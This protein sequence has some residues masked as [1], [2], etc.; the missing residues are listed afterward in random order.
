LALPFKFRHGVE[1]L[2]STVLALGPADKLHEKELYD[3]L[4]AIAS[5]ELFHVWNVKTIRPVE[6]MPY[7]YAT[8]NYAR[9]G[10]V[11]EGVTTYYGDLFLIRCHYFSIPEYFKQ[12]DK[13]LMKH[14]H[15]AGRFNL[16]V[17]DSSFDTWLDGYVIGIPDR[18][19]SIYDEGSLIALILDLMIINQSNCKYSLDDVMRNLYN[20]FGKKKHGYSTKDFIAACE[21]VAGNSLEKFFNE[22]VFNAKSYDEKLL[23]VLN[24][25]GCTIE[26]SDSEKLHEKIF[27][28][29][30]SEESTV[31]VITNVYPDSPAD[32]AG[33]TKDDAILTVNGEEVNKNL[34]YLLLKYADEEMILKVNSFHKEKL[35]QIHV[36]G[37]NYFNKY[38]VV[39]SQEI[40]E[41]QKQNFDFWL[42]RRN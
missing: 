34:D 3:E 10:F 35:I 18:K 1:H 9:T 40:N 27:G 17:A 13:R 12:I 23:E 4:I 20:N 29:K 11:Y 26:I 15:N 21:N 38:A 37:K 36:D 8:E 5:H 16:S 7:K 6:M 30:I 2:N 41:M 33:L 28:I 42:G 22:Y 14:M 31:G 24:F 32:S 39:Q 25:V 19:V